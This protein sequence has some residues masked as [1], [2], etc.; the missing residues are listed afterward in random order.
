[1]GQSLGLDMAQMG[2]YPQQ[3]QEANMLNPVYP[4]FN[5]KR[6]G[7][8]IKAQLKRFLFDNQISGSVSAS[9]SP[10]AGNRLQLNAGSY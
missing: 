8:S 3:V 10:R 9:P 7:F 5:Q 6:N 1:M 2:Y 4:E